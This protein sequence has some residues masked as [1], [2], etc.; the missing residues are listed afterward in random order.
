MLPPPFLL[1][2]DQRQKRSL[3][4]NVIPFLNKIVFQYTK[5]LAFETEAH[6]IHNIPLIR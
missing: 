6:T 3:T 5:P 2:T 1:S 4:Q